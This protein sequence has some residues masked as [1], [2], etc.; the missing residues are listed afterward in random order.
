MFSDLLPTL[1]LA[2]SR[3]A[4][5]TSSDCHPECGPEVGQIASNGRLIGVVSPFLRVIVVPLRVPLIVL[6]PN[7]G[8]GEVLVIFENA[9]GKRIKT[10]VKQL[11]FQPTLP[12]LL[13]LRN[14]KG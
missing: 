9:D 12:E 13:M 11:H 4:K 2:A 1:S 8:G 5:P 10:M 3:S 14:R 7:G 6:K